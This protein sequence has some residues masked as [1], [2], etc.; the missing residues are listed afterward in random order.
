MKY[1]NQANDGTQN[2]LLRFLDLR[3]LAL[4]RWKYLS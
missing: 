4:H 2:F 3:K 1:T